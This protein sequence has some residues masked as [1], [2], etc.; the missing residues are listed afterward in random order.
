MF[1]EKGLDAEPTVFSALSENEIG[2]IAVDE[3]S[4]QPLL[5]LDVNDVAE[6]A[7]EFLGSI[8]G[9]DLAKL[10]HDYNENINVVRKQHDFIVDAKK[11]YNLAISENQK[12]GRE[13]VNLKKTIDVQV[14]AIQ[15][16]V[17]Y[18]N[19]LE[20]EIKSLKKELELFKRKSNSS[21][22]EVTKI[23]QKNEELKKKAKQYQGETNQALEKVKAL[24]F[25]F[26][27]LTK[28]MANLSEHSAMV[29][30]ACKEAENIMFATGRIVEATTKDK[31]GNEYKFAKIPL[32]TFS[33]NDINIKLRGMGLPVSLTHNY[34]YA[35][36]DTL[37]GQQYFFAGEENGDIINLKPR[38]FSKDKEVRAYITKQFE[39]ETVDF[40]HFDSDS[41]FTRIAKNWSTIIN[42]TMDKF[43]EI[44]DRFDPTIKETYAKNCVL[45]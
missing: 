28:D 14:T 12:L 18:A 42:T 25:K 2:I 27:S 16:S 4:Q 32:N 31:K 15:K 39:T 6:N 20:K 5:N 36:E 10:V 38:D 40:T 30:Q 41:D 45:K 17:I 19:D 43:I 1:N 24:E 22:T 8:L 35:V 23:K 13:N 11:S 44:I 3:H 26:K 37:A 34:C 7:M 21:D 33:K 9:E 29:I